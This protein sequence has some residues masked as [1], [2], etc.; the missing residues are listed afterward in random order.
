MFSRK[1]VSCLLFCI[2]IVAADIITAEMTCGPVEFR[3]GEIFIPGCKKLQIPGTP[4]LPAQSIVLA[5]PPGAI[6]NSVAIQ[7]APAQVVDR[8]DIAIAPPSL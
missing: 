8:V 7:T 2:C 5:L 4:V 6:V 1:I 3:G